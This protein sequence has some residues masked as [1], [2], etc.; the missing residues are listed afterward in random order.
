MT[1]KEQDKSITNSFAIVP[2]LLQTNV[3]IETFVFLYP[4]ATVNLIRE[5][6]A[7][8]LKL[9]VCFR[10]FHGQGP[11]VSIKHG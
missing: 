6:L 4:R 7:N 3:G 5:D 8:Q 11:Q 2:V 1:I 10:S 9:N